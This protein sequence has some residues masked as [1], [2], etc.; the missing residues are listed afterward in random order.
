[1]SIR[2]NTW[3]LNNKYDL[4]NSGWDGY[5]DTRP[6]LKAYSFGYNIVGELGLNDTVRRSSPTQIPGTEWSLK[7]FSKCI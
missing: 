4:T 2:K 6:P 7:D 3:N 1:M 5:T